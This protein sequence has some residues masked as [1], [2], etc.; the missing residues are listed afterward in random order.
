MTDFVLNVTGL[1]LL[2]LFDLAL[3]AARSGFLQTSFARLLAL[4]EKSDPHVVRAVTLLPELARLRAS[5]NLL[6]LLA[7]FSLAGLILLM[8]SWLS[9]RYPLLI[10]V[11]ALLLAALLL[12]GFEWAVEKAVSRAP[13]IWVVRLA[14]FVRLL[15][16]VTSVLLTPLTGSSGRQSTTETGSGV[17]EAEVKTLVGAGEEEGIFEREE[18]KM[19]FSIFQLGDTLA[20]EIMVPRID[21][22]ALDVHTPLPE[23]VD[24]LLQSGHSRVPVFEDTVDNTLGLLYGKDLLRVWREGGQLD[25]LRNL[26][27]PAYFVPEAK[28]VDELLTEMQSQRIHMAIVVDEYGGAAGLVTLEDIV[29]EI[30]G[31]IQDEY[32]QAEEAPYQELKDGS[33]SFQG[34]IDLDDFNEIMG[35]KLPKDE[36][37][38]LGGYIYDRLGRVPAVGEQ[39]HKGNLLLTVEQVSARRIRKVRASWTLPEAEKEPHSDNG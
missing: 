12:F 36:A 5:L 6:L 1:F 31:E 39:L 22:L 3:I 4:R 19:I 28:K 20:R 8:V 38:T 21:M 26:L 24:A 18:R 29:E 17:T 23:A 10:S 14:V 7:R 13:E 34:K 25:S 11:L 9:L 33:Y 2:L 16:L 30:V 15:M 35:S 32:D 27:R 37:E